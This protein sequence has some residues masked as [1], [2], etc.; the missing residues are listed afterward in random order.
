MLISEG[1]NVMIETTDRVN[2]MLLAGGVCGRVVAYPLVDVM[3][4]LNVSREM[5]EEAEPDDRCPT[6]DATW[7][8]A[9]EYY[10]RGRVIRRGIA[11]E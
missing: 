11:I 6:C 5:V 9:I 10:V 8:E 4:E 3:A 7:S 1:G 2:D